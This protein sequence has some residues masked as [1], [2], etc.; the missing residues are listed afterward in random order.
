MKHITKKHVFVIYGIIIVV[1]FITVFFLNIFISYSTV[2][3]AL[4]SSGIITVPV[5]LL[6][7]GNGFILL[8][9]GDADDAFENNDK[10]D[11]VSKDS[12]I[13]IF[14]SNK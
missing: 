11:N 3:E 4:I 14:R 6:G 13:N 5:A 2:K 12:F 1:L 7:A 8:F 9:L 10:E